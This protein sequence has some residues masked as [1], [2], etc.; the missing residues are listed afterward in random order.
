LRRRA[1]LAL[2]L[3][4]PACAA[5]G[6][7]LPRAGPFPLPAPASSALLPLGGLALDTSAWGFGGFSGLHLA[8]D[9]ALTAISDRGHWWRARLELDGAGAPRAV[10]DVRH[11]PLRDAAGAPL[12]GT[13]QADAEALAQLPGGEWLVGF[14][15][16]H[17]LQRHRHLEGPG[18]PFPAPPGLADAPGNGGLEALAVLADGRLLALAEGLD[19]TAPGTARAW[20]GEMRGRRVA[21]TPRDYQPE[22]PMRPT[23]AAGLPG[24]GA[25]V[26][27]REFSF[28]G[29]FRCRLARLGAGSLAGPGPLRGE[30]L[31]RLPGDGP[32]E[33]WEGVAVARAGG[34]TLVALIS[35]DNERTAQRSL[36]LLYALT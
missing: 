17:R 16:R 23:G 3:G 26:V 30:T 27:E 32:A 11:G 1:L 28:F 34:R 14:E 6:Q 20:L 21:W 15:R 35:D 10:A 5:L 31:L 22:S 7:D 24:G 4:L 36:I 2:P 33:N 12:R 29:G 9:L 25:L 19:G 8:P 13:R 18:A